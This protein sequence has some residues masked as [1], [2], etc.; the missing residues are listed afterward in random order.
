MDATHDV[1]TEKASLVQI[2]IAFL[3]F[4]F[5]LGHFLRF[6]S[7]FLHSS[8]VD[9]SACAVQLVTNEILTNAPVGTNCG[10]KLVQRKTNFPWTG[11][12]SF[13]DCT[14]LESVSISRYVA[15]GGAVLFRSTP[16]KSFFVPQ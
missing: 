1:A 7:V 3:R 13:R 2:S 12:K 14:G 6:V 16:A 5:I 11:Q 10:W 15:V 9:C 8:L 4:G